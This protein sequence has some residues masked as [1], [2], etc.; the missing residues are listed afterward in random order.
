MAIGETEISDRFTWVRTLLNL[1]LWYVFDLWR[2]FT[3]DESDA[4]VF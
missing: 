4:G 2:F 1:C 3:R